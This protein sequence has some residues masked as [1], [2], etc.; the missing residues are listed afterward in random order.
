MTPADVSGED[1]ELVDRFLAIFDQEPPNHPRWAF[2]FAILA[3]GRIGFGHGI[4]P[5]VPRD[6]FIRALR[7]RMTDVVET[8]VAEDFLVKSLHRDLDEWVRE[9]QNLEKYDSDAMDFREVLQ[10]LLDDPEF[11]IEWRRDHPNPID[12]ASSDDEFVANVERYLDD[13]VLA[14][15]ATA[16]DATER[17]SE[18]QEWERLTAEHLSNETI[19]R[20]TFKRLL[21]HLG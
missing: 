13:S 14:R 12:P 21:R 10:Q 8:G 15:P 6:Q 1:G 17:W 18:L 7:E 9:R 4:G 11:R 3:A 16:E 20:W 2:T 5:D 19:K